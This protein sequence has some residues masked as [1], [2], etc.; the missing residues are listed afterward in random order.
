M[1]VLCYTLSELFPQRKILKNN[2][3]ITSSKRR[4]VKFEISDM[5]FSKSIQSQTSTD[6]SHAK[7]IKRLSFSNKASCA[8]YHMAS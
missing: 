2:Y 3:E 5:L 6:L 4:H 7:Y 8:I 1:L